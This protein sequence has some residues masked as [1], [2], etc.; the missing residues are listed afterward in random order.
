[1][2]RLLEF[3]RS[4]A[5]DILFGGTATARYLCSGPVPRDVAIGVHRNSVAAALVNVIRLSCPTLAALVDGNFLEQSVRDYTRA[6]PPG[7]ACL[8][9]FG[10]GFAGFLETYPP[11]KGFPFFA[12]VVRF[13]MAVDHASHYLPGAYGTSIALGPD[14]SFRLLGSLRQISTRYPVDMIRDEVEAGRAQ[15]LERIDMTPRARHFA[16]WS[17]ESGASV[18]KLTAPASAFLT[19]LLDGC[20]GVEAVANTL[21]GVEFEEALN[22]VRR[23]ILIAP[24]AIISFDTKSGVGS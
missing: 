4:F 12:D 1:M 16:V 23:E 11:A 18:K 7:S 14:I 9:N 3:Q 20:D 21:D 17:G 13:D 24:L 22:A 10:D 8:A 5:T 19:A 6:R 2:A 15:E